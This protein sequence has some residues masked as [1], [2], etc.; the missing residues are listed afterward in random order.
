MTRSIVG[1]VSL[2]V[3][4]A[5]PLG[6]CSEPTTTP[7]A[8]MAGGNMMDMP[9][10]DGSAVD[11][12]QVPLYPGAKMVDMKITPHEQDDMMDMAFDIPADAATARHWYLETLRPKGFHL[13]EVGT[14][15]IGTDP[16]GRPVRIDVTP[17]PGGTSRSVISKG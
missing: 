2:W 1:A 9:M 16:S 8:A 13:A 4:V 7:K 17:T 12:A 3:V 5:L 15:L 11:M 10:P 6:G 14:T